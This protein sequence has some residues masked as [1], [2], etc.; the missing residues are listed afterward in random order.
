MQKARGASF[1]E[2]SDRAHFYVCAPK[3]Q[4]LFSAASYKPW[5]N[6][7]V[8]G[9]WL[10]DLWTGDK[11]DNDTYDDLARRVKT[12]YANRKRDVDLVRSAERDKQV[13]RTLAAV[14][15]ELAK[16]RASFRSFPEVT[17]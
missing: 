14:D 16:L 8:L 2:A 3:K 13:G 5:E 11:L 15:N 6:Y 4:T 12:G 7:K 1:Q 17:D 9:K 10:D